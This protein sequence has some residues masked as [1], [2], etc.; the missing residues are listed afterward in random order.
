MH[1]VEGGSESPLDWRGFGEQ[2]RKRGSFIGTDWVLL[3]TPERTRLPSLSDPNAF[4]L[5]F[6]QLRVEQHTLSRAACHSLRLCAVPSGVG[7]LAAADL[8]S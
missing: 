3:C 4:L 5:R 2:S 1:T 7:V 8:R 6:A